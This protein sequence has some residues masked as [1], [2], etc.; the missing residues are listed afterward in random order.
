[1][2]RPS[3]PSN[4]MTLTQKQIETVF[5]YATVYTL[6][7]DPVAEETQKRVRKTWPQSDLGNSNWEREDNVVFLRITP[8]YDDY[9]VQKDITHVYDSGNDTLY[10]QV[11]YHRCYSIQWVCYG[12]DSAEDADTLRIGILRDP[13][14]AF[15][16]KYG[17]AVK[18]NIRESVRNPEP[19]ESGDWWERNDVMA[20]F[21]IKF[22]R[23]YAEGII[24]NIPAIATKFD[25]PSDQDVGI[26]II[27]Q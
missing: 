7:L 12:P 1:M 18:P 24:E 21:Y 25:L 19:D 22:S 23:K 3:I 10:E 26:N 14:K 16:L 9:A 13:V 4:V 11:D 20:Q 27:A 6:G 5:W 2:P 15:L 17:I 8:T